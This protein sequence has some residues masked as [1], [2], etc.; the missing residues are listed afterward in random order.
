MNKVFQQRVIKV[1]EQLSVQYPNPKTE[2][3][4]VNPYELLM[5]VILSAQCT[6]V[7]VNQ[8]TP[9]LFKHFPTAASMAKA[10]PSEVEAIIKSCGFFRAKTKA[11]IGCCQQIVERFGGIV[12]HTLEEL[13][14]LPGVGRKT[15]S[16]V[17]N[18]AFD[19]PAIAVDTHVG[20]V[21]NRLG[22]AHSDDPFKVEMELRELVP[23]EHWTNINGTL[24]LHGRRCCQ[25]RKPRCFE[26][27]VAKLCPFEPKTLNAT[28]AK[29]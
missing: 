28:T 18:Q 15:A 4:Y 6:D 29:R 12:P 16:V 20:R 9:A 2:L 26:C 22:W 23:Q 21:A 7:R 19:I 24:I 11:M 17:L 8:T 14:T 3:T 10:R 25:A 13:V 5:A 27:S 1:L